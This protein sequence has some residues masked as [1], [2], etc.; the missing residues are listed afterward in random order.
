MNKKQ[1]L[2]NTV[3]FFITISKSVRWVIL[4]AEATPKIIT[5]G[6]AFRRR[7]KKYKPGGLV[8]STEN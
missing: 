2:P 4:D 8:L 3:F 7:T 6:K 1:R 5:K